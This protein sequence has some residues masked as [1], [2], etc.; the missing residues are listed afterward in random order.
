MN[1]F[2]TIG[3]S[4]A[5]SFSATPFLPLLISFVGNKWL[6][7][8]GGLLN[9]VFMKELIRKFNRIDPRWLVDLICS[10]FVFLVST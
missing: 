3:I 7:V 9:T 8:I 6:L 10:R 1:G 4:Y 2:T 5:C